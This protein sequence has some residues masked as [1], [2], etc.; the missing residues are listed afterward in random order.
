MH[1]C[2]GVRAH[3]VCNGRS[4]GSH[5]PFLLAALTLP[6]S[7]CRDVGQAGVG[8]PPGL[9]IPRAFCPR[10]APPWLSATWRQGSSGSQGEACNAWAWSTSVL[11]AGP[12]LDTLLCLQ[13]SLPRHQA[14]PRSGSWLSLWRE[15]WGGCRPSAGGGGPS[16]HGGACGTARGRC[17]APARGPAL[18]APGAA[19][20][21]W[22]CDPR[23]SVCPSHRLVVGASCILC[24]TQV[25]DRRTAL[26]TVPR[27]DAQAQPPPSPLP[28]GL[29]P[30]TCK[31]PVCP[32]CSGD[33]LRLT[34][35]SGAS[36]RLFLSR[37]L[38]GQLDTAVRQLVLP[39][40][41]PPLASSFR[42]SSKIGG[43][44]ERLQGRRRREVRVPAPDRPHV[45]RVSLRGTWKAPVHRGPTWPLTCI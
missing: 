25:M 1:V 10:P 6:A 31:G 15:P 16:S 22:P 8:P 40:D 21:R 18:G 4:A 36:G 23:I 34:S 14:V 12:S 28:W 9:C 29:P 13:P 41:Q 32:L 2:S 45:A 27:V 33:T 17:Q 3:R 26:L 35:E 43:Q 5:G 38:A 39:G 24:C 20:G 11:P 37:S 30:A 44:E 42:W 19:R 7:A